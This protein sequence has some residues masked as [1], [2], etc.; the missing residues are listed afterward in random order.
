MNILHV[1]PYFTPKRGGD[2]NVCYNLSKQ[3]VKHGHNVKIV[4]TDF[5]FD[6]EYAKSLNGIQV[7]PFMCIANIGLFLI[8]P[9]MKKWLKGNIKNFDIVH[10]HDFRSYQNCIVHH[11][12]SKY[13]I[14]YV[15]QPHASTSRVISKQRLKWLFDVIF[16]YRI[17][18]DATRI[19]AVSKEE[20]EYDKQMGAE[21][22]KISVIYNGMDIESFKNLPEY[23]RFRRKCGVEGIMILYLG[24]IHKSKGIDFLI[25]AFSRLI[26]EMDDVVLVIAGS[27]DG[28]KQELEKLVEKLNLSYKVKFTGFVDEKDKISAY[29]DANI[30][31]HTVMYMGGVG[32]TPLEAILCDTPVIVT[33]ECGEVVKEV[34][35]GYIVKYGDINDLKEKIKYVIKNP[36]E[37]E[38]KIGRGKKYINDT[39]TWDNVVE[40]V[41][42][43]YSEAHIRR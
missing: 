19:I 12:V 8:S 13:R 4:T 14:P 37:G 29:L 3:L 1:I 17:L 21:D 5:E 2:V 35:C 23:G 24:R 38:E 22:K 41:L 11:Y 27:D 39:L 32:L 28:Y 43:I 25:N 18:R 7:I 30:F 26:K 20:A 16:G 31:M 10:L 15:L 34:N 33:E 42:K 9:S 40:K 36:E 6:E